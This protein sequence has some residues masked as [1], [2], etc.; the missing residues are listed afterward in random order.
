M[1][2]YTVDQSREWYNALPGKKSAAALIVRHNDTVLMV[3]DDYKDAMTFPGGV[4]DPDESPLDAAIRETVEE[5]KLVIPS[6]STSFFTVA[7]VP[8]VN[9][10]MDRYQFFFIADIDDD[11]KATAMTVPGIE[12]D[13]WVPLSQIAERAARPTYAVIQ[14]MLQ[15]GNSIPYFEALK[16]GVGPWQT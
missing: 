16:R 7:Y 10:F 13:D 9:G 5:T 1:T 15:S 6:E 4:I 14:E 2:K 11:M 12:Y 3:K 8:P